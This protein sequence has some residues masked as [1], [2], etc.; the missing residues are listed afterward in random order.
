MDR[1][2]DTPSSFAEVLAD[3][4]PPTPAGH[5]NAQRDDRVLPKTIRVALAGQPNVGKSTVFNLLTGLNQHV[6]NW[7]GKTVEQK[8]GT[9]AYDGTTFEITDLPGTYSLTAN[10]AEE[11]IARDFII[12]QRPDVVVAI[13]GAATLERNL[14]LVA[15]LLPLPSPV[16]IG[17]NMMDVADQ[18]GIR[19]EPHVL[20]AVLGVR[21]IPMTATRNLGVQELV[22]EVYRLAVGETAYQ[23]V[24][25]RIRDDHADLL[26][27]IVALIDGHVPALYP[28]DWMALKLLEGDA[29]VTEMMSQ[30]TPHENW[31]RVQD[32]LRRHDDALV[33][34]ASGRYEWIQRLVRAALTRPHAGQVSLTARLDRWTT[35][36]LWGLVIL[37]GVL[38]LV[39]FLTY[40]LGSPLQN[41]TETV[42]VS[43]LADLVRGWMVGSPVWLSGLIVDGIIG[44]VG[45]VLTFLPILLIFFAVMGTLEDTGYMAR[46]AYVMDNFMHAIGLHGKSFLPLFLGFGC[47]VPAVMGTRI[48]ESRRSRLVTLMLAPLIPCTARLAVLTFLAPAFFGQR[49]F[50]VSI[51]LIV[52]SL[53]IMALAAI[54]INRV[55]FRAERAGFIMELPLYH[56]PNWRTIGLLVWQRTIAFVKKAGTLILVV[57]AAIWL[58]SY[59]PSGQINSSY[60]ASLGRWL[61]PVGSLMGMSWEMIVA[62]LTSFIAKENS[63][64]TLGVLY[65]TAEEGLTDVMQGIG[66][67]AGLAF[68]VVQMLF[69]PC[70]ATV[71]AIKQESDSW[72]WTLTNLASLLV[73]SLG[74][75]ILAYQLVSRL[76]P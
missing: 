42:L 65:N 71:A 33:A 30:V 5:R 58:L 27:Q 32:I 55:V 8:T 74:S 75:G 20:E 63:I 28:T 59:L 1:Q 7:P 19:I 40:T 47:S 68:L 16:V 66:A 44:G 67:A 31:A 18:E 34:V 37:V 21:V 56:L 45:S 41:W 43:G 26:R 14:Y 36:P 24:L 22:G 3:L 49:A 60:L 25:P 62:L 9:F 12:K 70:V 23:P 11:V 17:L 69:I 64:A 61:E 72:V 35:H 29:V 52:Y 15:E 53:A 2:Q 73:I 51:G 48:I 76:A 4:P 6:G 39:F 54:I 38:A 46:A 10:S 50:A 13:I 57:S